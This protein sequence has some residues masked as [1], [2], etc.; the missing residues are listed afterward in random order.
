MYIGVLSNTQSHIPRVSNARTQV[1]FLETSN[2]KVCTG[3]GG[4][5]LEIGFKQQISQ[6]LSH[7]GTFG[8]VNLALELLSIQFDEIGVGAS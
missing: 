3:A 8:I 2:C 5:L 1:G 7:E 6:D 4:F